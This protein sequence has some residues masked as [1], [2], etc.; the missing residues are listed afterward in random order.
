MNDPKPISEFQ[1]QKLFVQ[2]IN[3]K[4]KDYPH[5]DSGFHI[6]N[7][8]KRSS[9]TGAFLKLLGVRKG[10]WDWLFLYPSNGKA[11][12]AIEFKKKGGK[13]SKEQKDFQKI[14][15]R[16]NFETHVIDDFYFAVKLTEKYFKMK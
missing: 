15:I 13:L 3:L 14:L 7:G 9:S 10:V 6:P 4:I 12:L 11:G 5:L 8:E 2:W 16:A 1:L